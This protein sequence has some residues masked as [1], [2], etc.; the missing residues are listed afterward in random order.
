MKSLLLLFFSVLLLSSTG[1]TQNVADSQKRAVAAY[2]DLAKTG[3]PLHTKF[4]ELYQQAKETNAAILATTD[5]PLALAK[6]ASEALTPKALAP[7]AEPEPPAKPL[8]NPSKGGEPVATFKE[9]AASFP[10]SSIGLSNQRP[11]N[12][13]DVSFD[14]RKTDSL[15]NPILGV[16]NFDAMGLEYQLVFHWTTDRWVFT[17]I[18]NR[19]NGKDFTGLGGGDYIVGAGAVKRLLDQYK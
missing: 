3:S 2:P 14:V 12:I 18:F 13:F 6:Q 4:L 5:W 8:P 10:K 16:L 11:Y 15:V 17:S 7:P 19:K 1:L 9:L